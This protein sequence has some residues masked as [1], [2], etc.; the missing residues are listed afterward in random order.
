MGG[1]K[2]TS[3]EKP[4]AKER[5][6]PRKPANNSNI[7]SGSKKRSGVSPAAKALTPKGKAVAT[8]GVKALSPKATAIVKFD[9]NPMNVDK[10]DL[11]ALNQKIRIDD[12]KKHDTPFG[13]RLASRNAVAVILSFMGRG[14]ENAQL[15]QMLTMRSR[16][17]FITQEGLTGFLQYFNPKIW[18][19]ELQN[20]TELVASI[21]KPEVDRTIKGLSNKH[22][23]KSQLE[24]LKKE[25]FLYWIVLK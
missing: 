3:K 8:K 17:F 23:A 19:H 16:C 2:P 18:L 9:Y 4:V 25:T 24:W 13:Q 20:N 11:N 14:P 22:S 7:R 15:M 21:G 5:L 6:A 10:I 1:E 12:S